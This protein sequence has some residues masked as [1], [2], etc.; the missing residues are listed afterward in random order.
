MLTS[1][2]PLG[3][4]G[5]DMPLAWR[6][7]MICTKC[8][9]LQVAQDAIFDARSICQREYA[10]APEVTVYGDP[11]F[12]FAYVP[13]HLHHM[14][15]ELVRALPSCGTAS[16]SRRVCAAC[17][18]AFAPV[19]CG[20]P[21]RGLTAGLQVKN[22]L[23][24]VNDRYEDAEDEPPPVRVVVAEGAEDVCIKVPLL[25]VAWLMGVHF[26]LLFSFH[27]PAC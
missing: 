17:A 11:S 4:P 7:G 26:I 21:M 1:C 25:C 14:T 3:I 13:S 20:I 12:T 5:A 24:A 15:F 10:S 16:A 2:G 23:R 18:H 27:T 8:S 22:S 19:S 6:A 9:P